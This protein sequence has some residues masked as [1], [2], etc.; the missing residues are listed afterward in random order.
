MTVRDRDGTW[1]YHP[2]DLTLRGLLILEGC[3]APG[4]GERAAGVRAA[5]PS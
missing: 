4:P 2:P 5:R 1:R 3:A